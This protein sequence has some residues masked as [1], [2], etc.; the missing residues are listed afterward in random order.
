MTNLLAQADRIAESGAIV[1]LLGETGVGKELMARR[2]HRKSLRSNAPYVIVDTPT[3]PESLLESEMFGHEKGAFTGA[4]RQKS[5]RIELADRGTLFLDEVGELPLSIQGKLLR[6]LEQKTFSRIGSNRVLHSDFRLV[7][8]TNRNLAE[9]VARG[10]FREDLYYR[11]NVVPLEIPPL[12][13]RDRD[14]V[15]LARHFL[16]LYAKRFNRPHLV[17]TPSEEEE[18]T[19]YD[20]PGNVRELRNVMERAVLLSSGERLALN[21]P[22]DPRSEANHSFEDCPTMDNLQRRY[23]QYV[24]ERTGNRISG[25]GGAAEVLGMDRATLYH[26]MKKLGLR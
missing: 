18:L 9:E 10:R 8:A 6:V 22:V 7:A 20:W 5:G 4:D 2:I 21:L 26:R 12:R 24:L 23:I 15:L 14:V 3:I 17:L 19:A 13:E 25:S 16:A 11:L 1:L